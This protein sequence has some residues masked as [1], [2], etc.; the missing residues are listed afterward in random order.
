MNNRR[1]FLI[2]SALAG[3]TRFGAVNAL[4]QA[5]DYKALVCIFMF[6]GNDGNHM[7]IPQTQ[8]E[9]NSYRAHSGTQRSHIAVSRHRFYAAT[10]KKNSTE[11]SH[12]L[13]DRI[14]Q[15]TNPKIIRVVEIDAHG[16]DA[17]AGYPIQIPPH[18]YDPTAA[19]S[20]K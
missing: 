11:R 6:G 16:N 15:M 19:R 17:P 10:L 13:E 9:V 20:G 12:R 2:M 3:L 18:A 1:E 14:D 7:I 8:S 5:S 4:A